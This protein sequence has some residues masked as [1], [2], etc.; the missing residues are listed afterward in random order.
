MMHARGLWMFVIVCFVAPVAGNADE[1]VAEQV[2]KRWQNLYKNRAESLAVAFTETSERIVT[3]SPQPLLSYSNPVRNVQGHGS[4]FL[5]TEAGRPVLIGGFWSALEPADPATRRLSRE[6][7]SLAADS[8]AVDLNGRKTWISTQPGI[9]WTIVKDTAEPLK[10]RP[11]RL[12]Q[13]RRIVERVRAEIET[14]ES[15]L[16]LM[17]QPIYRYPEDTGVLDGAIFAFV[18]GTDPE[19]FA[20]VEARTAA[21]GAAEWVLGF[22][23]FTNFP[24]R[25][26]FDGV[27][28]YHAE[29]WS[30]TEST[31]R[32]HLSFAIERHPADLTD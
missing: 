4:V 16:R 10:S 29:R 3:L 19:L 11:L 15:E 8:I 9:E 32:H 14:Q 23:H 26:T 31:G 13:M 7:H 25:A 27:E 1:N 5:W 12:A 20:I 28:I 17:P 30:P 6:L 21:G 22:A 2:H 24:V 18:M